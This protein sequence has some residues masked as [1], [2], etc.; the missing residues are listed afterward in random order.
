M[1][2]ALRDSKH[3]G[4]ATPDNISFDFAAFKK[5]RDEHIKELNA[6]YENNWSR[7]GIGKNGFQDFLPSFEIRP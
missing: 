7:E 1:A 3:Y 2:E 4:F 6:G 5:L